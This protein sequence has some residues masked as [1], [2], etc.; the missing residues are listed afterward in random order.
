MK[1]QGSLSRY[2]FFAPVPTI[3]KGIS[4]ESIFS[5]PSQSNPAGA[6][7]SPREEL[8]FAYF[9]ITITRAHLTKVKAWIS[10]GKGFNHETDLHQSKVN[11]SIK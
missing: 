1:R 6:I 10:K 8:S 7:Q 3:Q 9:I 11:K 2:A 5:G 4:Y